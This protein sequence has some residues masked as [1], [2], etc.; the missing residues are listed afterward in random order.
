[1]NGRLAFGIAV[2]VVG[3]GERPPAAVALAETQQTPTAAS[4]SSVA[5]PVVTQPSG[6]AGAPG[7]SP[8]AL[9]AR[10]G[11]AQPTTLV[12]AAPDRRCVA[13]CQARNDTDGDGLVN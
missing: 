8:P 2:A 4:A 10:W 6:A 5:T 11:T 9:G 13:M 1:M 12:A 7:T 3:C